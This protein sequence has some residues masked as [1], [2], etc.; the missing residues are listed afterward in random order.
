MTHKQGKE[1]PVYYWDRAVSLSEITFYS[2]RMM[3][4]W[5]NNLFLGCL[6]GQHIIKLVIKVDKVVA[7]ERL[8]E[9]NGQ[10]IQINYPV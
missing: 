3:A 2:G 6:S 4:E 8:L 10:N 1:Q 5:K 9:Y 7:E